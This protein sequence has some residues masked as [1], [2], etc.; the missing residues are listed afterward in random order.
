MNPTRLSMYAAILFCLPLCVWFL[1]L[2]SVNDGE[3]GIVLQLARQLVQNLALLQLMFLVIFFPRIY[4]GA[5][6]RT[7]LSGAVVYIC[8]PIP[9]LAIAWLIGIGR[10]DSLILWQ[11]GVF[12]LGILLIYL[13]AGFHRL[14]KTENVYLLCLAVVQVSLV[15]TLWSNRA[16]FYSWNI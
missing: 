13:S 2:I 7:A 15:L 6:W 1:S 11:A 5:N 8:T 14:V 3:S 4:F 10:I 9:V 12:C 16:V